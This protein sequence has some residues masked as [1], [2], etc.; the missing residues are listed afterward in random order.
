MNPY[1]VFETEREAI[2]YS[3]WLEGTGPEISYI[4]PTKDGSWMV[5]TKLSGQ[6]SESYTDECTIVFDSKDDAFEYSKFLKEKLFYNDINISKKKNGQ[7]CVMAK[8]DKPV[9]Q[10]ELS[11]QAEIQKKPERDISILPSMP[12]IPKGKTV[13]TYRLGEYRVSFVRDAPSYASGAGLALLINYQYKYSLCFYRDAE[14][15]FDYVFAHESSRFGGTFLGGFTPYGEHFNYGEAEKN[16]S[17]NEFLR[18]GF[19][20]GKEH[21]GLDSA[22][23][24]VDESPDS[25][26]EDELLFDLSYIRRRRLYTI[27]LAV[28]LFIFFEVKHFFTDSAIRAYASSTPYQI[29]GIIFVYSYLKLVI[30]YWTREPENAP[31]MR[32]LHHDWYRLLI[33]CIKFVAFFNGL[34]LL[35]YILIGSNAGFME[36]FWPF[37][38]G[39]VAFEIF[40]FLSARFGFFGILTINL[41]TPLIFAL[42]LAYLSVR[43]V[44]AS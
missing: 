7:W 17:L 43:V 15:I 5:G 10:S 30:D 35:F 26:I 22:T 32:V 19:A 13:K 21:L 9:S 1:A 11:V 29:A 42:G 40:A 27:G 24:V 33:L 4:K 41:L 36:F 6:E 12:N 28:A 8:P 2:E 16:I 18:L 44:S 37:V 39:Y 3:K 20:Q 31:M 34:I 14:R 25:S 23:E 38:F